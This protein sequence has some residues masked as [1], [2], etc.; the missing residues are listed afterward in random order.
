MPVLRRQAQFLQYSLVQ[1]VS[2]C[3]EFPESQPPPWDILGSSLGSPCTGRWVEGTCWVPAILLA[4]AGCIPLEHP[5][6][7]GSAP[8]P[9]VCIAQMF[10]PSSSSNSNIPDK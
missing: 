6:A 9:S 2:W 4:G 8:R 1:P 7:A 10:T 3:G 5:Q